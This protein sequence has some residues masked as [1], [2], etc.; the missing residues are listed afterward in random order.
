[1]NNHAEWSDPVGSH[2]DG[3]RLLDAA[4]KGVAPRRIGQ[5][6]SVTESGSA[7]DAPLPAVLMSTDLTA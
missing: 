3:V 7:A 2:G 4:A 6:R 5:N 1:M